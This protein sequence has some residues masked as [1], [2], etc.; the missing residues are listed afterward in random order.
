[1]AVDTMFL[2]YTSLHKQCNATNSAYFH[3]L[4]V[5]T[6]RA[7][8]LIHFRSAVTQPA[9]LAVLGDQAAIT[10]KKLP[11]ARVES[12]TGLQDI[13]AVVHQFD[14]NLSGPD[15]YADTMMANVF[16]DVR[17]HT[18]N[19]LENTAREDL[20]NKQFIVATVAF[21]ASLKPET[22]KLM[23][24][25]A[26]C[27]ACEEETVQ[28]HDVVR[29]SL[30]GT[31]VLPKSQEGGSTLR[32]MAYLTMTDLICG[33]LLV[34]VAEDGKIDMTLRAPS[35]MDIIS[36]SLLNNRFIDGKVDLDTEEMKFGNLE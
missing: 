10:F 17:Y 15:I 22:K 26:I 34:R 8:T 24:L 7:D 25:W 33:T 4:P 9:S 32:P 21:Q 31:L 27:P 19:F 11:S 1:M 30:N 18:V 35:R 16:T 5:L 23:C 6:G 13:V 28:P 29:E 14:K 36:S 2:A 20:T 12:I 3:G